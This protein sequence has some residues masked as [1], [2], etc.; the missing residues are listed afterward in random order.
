VETLGARSGSGQPPR[1]PAPG[2]PE[3]QAAVLPRTTRPWVCLDVG[4]VLI[5]E[6]RV[7]STWA[8]VLGLTRFTLLAALGAAIASRGDHTVAFELLGLPDWRSREPQVQRAYGGFSAD[9][10]YPDALPALA[11]LRASGLGVA[12]VGNQP[13]RRENELVALG[14]DVDVIATSE[15]LG[16]EKPEPEFFARVL[17]LLGGP[18]PSAVAYVGD[19]V[20]N[21]VEPSA[22]A[23]LNAVWLRRGPWAALQHDRSGAAA[24]VVDSLS[25]LAERLPG[26]LLGT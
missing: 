16:V 9:D 18:D 1:R 8:D 6:T 2:V 17:D 20:D 19:R 14:V 5:D 22:G 12:V 15:A 21:D 10:L 26:V 7:W 3:A 23:G 24:L 25:E 4:E 11:A 13:R